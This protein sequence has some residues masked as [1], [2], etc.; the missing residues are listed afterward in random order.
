MS[1]QE[2]RK[3]VRFSVAESE[4]EMEQD[5]DAVDIDEEHEHLPQIPRVLNW[6]YIALWAIA[7]AV[8]IYYLT[9]IVSQYNDSIA[10]PRSVVGLHP[11]EEL[12]FPKATICNW[13]S[14]PT[15]QTC[16]VCDIQPAECFVR[17]TMCGTFQLTARH[18]YSATAMPKIASVSSSN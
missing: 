2:K 17:S 3:S 18:R 14:F 5:L 12:D 11:E 9:T 1:E 15:N 10:N 7:F 6:A 13:N 16:E 4:T 8:F